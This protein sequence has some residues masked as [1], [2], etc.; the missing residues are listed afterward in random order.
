MKLITRKLNEAEKWRIV[1]RHK[2]Q[3]RE[4]MQMLEEAIRERDQLSITVAIHRIKVISSK[5]SRSAFGYVQKFR[6]S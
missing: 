6:K 4:A 3:M 5:M 1:N 2:R